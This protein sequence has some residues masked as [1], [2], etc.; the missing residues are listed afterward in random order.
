MSLESWLANGWL[1]RHVASAQETRDLL[2]AAAR[3]L[4]DANEDLSP[5]WRLAIAYNAALRLCTAALQA[6]GYRASR[7][8]RHYRT[9]AAL[10]LVLGVE[11]QEIARFLDICR[12]PSHSSTPF[13]LCPGL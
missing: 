3:D 13:F 4:A 1:V 6:A 8:Q 9:I 2:D 11:A 5:S 7:D 10:P 12:T